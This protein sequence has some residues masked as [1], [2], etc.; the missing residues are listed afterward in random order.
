MRFAPGNG[1]PPLQN[2]GGSEGGPSKTAQILL[3]HDNGLQTRAHHNFRRD[4]RVNSAETAETATK[5]PASPLLSADP[6]ATLTFSAEKDG[7]LRV[8]YSGWDDGGV[9]TF[10]PGGWVEVVTLNG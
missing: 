3:N 2:R 9:K 6:K 7:T 10:R 5:L 8:L 4:I 1:T